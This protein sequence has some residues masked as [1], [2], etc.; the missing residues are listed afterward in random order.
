M[1]NA[2]WV[3][4]PF[5]LKLFSPIQNSIDPNFFTSEH[6]FNLQCLAGDAADKHVIIVDDLVQTGGTQMECAKVHEFIRIYHSSISLL[7]QNF[8]TL[9][10]ASSKS[11]NITLL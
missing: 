5:A 8:S 6:S 11:R 9:P 1:S 2:E 4:D 10:N 3:M 7:S